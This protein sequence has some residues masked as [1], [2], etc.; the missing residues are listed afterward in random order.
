MNNKGRLSSNE[1]SVFLLSAALLFGMISRFLPGLQAGFPL[2]DGGMFLSMIRDLNASQYALPVATSYN[3]WDIPY[4][5]PPFGFYFVRLLSDVLGVS[6]IAA[7]LWLPALA[8]TFSIFAFYLLSSAILESR[9]VGALAAVFYALTPGA[10]AWFIMGGGLTRSFG[11]LFMLLSLYWVLRLFRNGGR[12]ELVSSVVFCSLTVLSHPEVGIHTAAGCVL[13]WLFYG[14][15]RRTALQALIVG[16]LTLLFSAPWW[17]TVHSQHGWAPFLSAITTG[18]L[19]TPFW[20]AFIDALIENQ[21]YIPLLIFIRVAGFVWGVWKR[22]Y[23]LVLW[24]IIPFIVESRSAPS[25][26]FYPFCVL[27]ALAFAEAL[28]ALVDYLGKRDGKLEF[29]ERK[30]VNI[31]LLLIIIYLFVESSLYGFRLVNTTLTGEERE[32]MAWIQ[33]NTPSGSRF[34]S[35]TGIQ[36]PE[37]DPFIEWFPVLTERRNQTTI[38]GLEWTLGEQFY[39]RYDDLAEVQ[40][41]GTED[42]ILNWSSRTGL[43]YDYLVIKETGADQNLINS[44]DHSDKYKL[45]YSTGTVGVY[46]LQAP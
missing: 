3:A 46:L 29:N 37:I 19:K 20:R 9:K 16:L 38:Q 27:M 21:T 45:L 5:Y 1:W 18:Y 26:V 42:C 6:E 8:N 28:P 30:W 39:E 24:T 10:S 7:L 23:F 13:L 22:N 17:G 33:K 14:R 40:A 35:I 11:S 31:S 34:L 15:T 44:M 36:S 12:L 2:N 43:D 41:C 32:A 25:I 4:A